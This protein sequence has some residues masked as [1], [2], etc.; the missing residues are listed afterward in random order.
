MPD[1]GGTDTVAPQSLTQSAQEKLRQLV[2]RIEKLEE[3][4]KSISDD[5]KETYAEAKGTGFDSKVLRQVVRYRKQD[6]TEREE[7]ETVRD[8]YLHALGEI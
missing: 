2:A 1:F 3:E 4:K 5:I 7:Q 6:R 8:L